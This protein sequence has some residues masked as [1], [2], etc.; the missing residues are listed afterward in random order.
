MPYHA[1]SRMKKAVKAF[2]KHKMYKGDKV[3]TANTHAEHL[4]LQK[5]GYGHTKP[6]KKK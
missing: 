6:R 5:Q 2:V 3:V 4:A 1:K